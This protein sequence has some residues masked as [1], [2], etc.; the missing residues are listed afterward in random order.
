M[1]IFRGG[2]T[3]SLLT[4]TYTWIPR[5]EKEGQDEREVRG[6]VDLCRTGT[7]QGT[8]AGPC[9]SCSSARYSG[10]FELEFLFKTFCARGTGLEERTAYRKGG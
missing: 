8:A 3:S 9:D 7:R 4:S 2:F 10:L 5:L 6:N 1:E